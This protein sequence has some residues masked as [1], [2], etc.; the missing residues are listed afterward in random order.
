MRIKWYVL[1]I[2]VFLVGMISLNVDLCFQKSS[3]DDS[4]LA[5]ESI[6]ALG[7]PEA[8]VVFKYCTQAGGYCFENGIHV[9]GI[10]MKDE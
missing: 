5:L 6:E 4:T 2:S 7:S 3:E 1:I 8:G 10:S 9:F